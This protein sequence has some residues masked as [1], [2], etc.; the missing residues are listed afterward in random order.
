MSKGKLDNHCQENGFTY[1]NKEVIST[2]SST[3]ASLDDETS[4]NSSDHVT[5]I[6]DRRTS[7][8]EVVHSGS[9]GLR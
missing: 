6:R 2:S 3:L 5:G 8:I 7:T 9:C 1:V 4:T